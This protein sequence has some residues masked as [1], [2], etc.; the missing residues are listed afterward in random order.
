LLGGKVLLTPD[1][2]KIIFSDIIMSE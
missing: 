1:M 2:E